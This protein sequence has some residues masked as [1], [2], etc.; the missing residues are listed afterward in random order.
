MSLFEDLFGKEREYK[1]PFPTYKCKYCEATIYVGQQHYCGAMPAAPPGVTKPVTALT[2]NDVRRI[3][4]EE[5]RAAL[6]K[7]GDS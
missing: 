4:R 3:V 5:L 6:G 7:T 2:E 1:W